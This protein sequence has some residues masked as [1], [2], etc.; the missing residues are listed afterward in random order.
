[1]ACKNIK[2]NYLIEIFTWLL[3]IFIKENYTGPS[4]LHRNVDRK[5]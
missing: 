4:E 1:M 5:L 2:Q 3:G